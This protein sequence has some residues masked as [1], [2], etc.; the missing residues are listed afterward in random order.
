MVIDH[1]EWVQTYSNGVGRGKSAELKYLFVGGKSRR[2]KLVWPRF[3]HRCAAKN[4][5]HT[6][7]ALHRYFF[8]RRDICR[9][10]NDIPKTNTLFRWQFLVGTKNVRLFTFWFARYHQSGK[11]SQLWGI[12]YS[13]LLFALVGWS[14]TCSRLNTIF[15]HRPR[16]FFVDISPSKRYSKNIRGR[17]WH[18]ASGKLIKWTPNSTYA[19]LLRTTRFNTSLIFFSLPCRLIYLLYTKIAVKAAVPSLV[20]FLAPVIVNIYHLN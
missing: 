5:A 19:A 16:S 8:K 13:R 15:S 14:G 10:A 20:W 1:E 3:Q 9:W 17:I 12:T 6:R 2:Y 7:S 18:R 4:M 11:C